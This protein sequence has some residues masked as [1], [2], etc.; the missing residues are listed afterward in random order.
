[1]ESLDAF[2]KDSQDGDNTVYE[3]VDAKHHPWMEIKRTGNSFQIVS[4]NPHVTESKESLG[5]K[6]DNLLVSIIKAEQSGTDLTEAG[7]TEGDNPFNPEDIRVHAKQFSLRL[8]ADMIKDEDIILRPDFQRNLVWTNLQKSRLIESILLRIPL[9]MFYFSEDEEGKITIVDGLQRLSTIKDFMDNKFPLKDLEYLNASCG[10]KYYKSEEGKEAIDGKYLR[11]FNQTQFSVNV[12]DP[13][14]P[15]KVKFDIFRRINTGGMPLN[16]QEIRNSLA[17]DGLRE[18]LNTMTNLQEFKSATDNSIR[19]SR[20]DDHELGLR[21]ILF[22]RFM[23]AKGTIED[24]SGYMDVSLD[25]LTDN[26]KKE[27]L[28]DL[29]TYVTSFSNA[30]RNCEYLFGS[31]FAFRKVRPSDLVAGARR[32]LINKALFVSCSV[33]LGGYDHAKLKSKNVEGALTAVLANRIDDDRKLLDY[34]SYSTNSRNNLLYV[35][36]KVQEIIKA[37]LIL[38]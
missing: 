21:F 19:T 38:S 22:Y 24:Y 16:N 18:T 23:E 34:L 12:I 17:G 31:R 30:M 10:G 26:L 32:Q 36:D 1:M 9:P 28:S 6:L 13:S 27:S 20:M 8:I 2:L 35:F 11:W 5:I 7:S 29:R 3:L 14:S 25:D 15:A 4:K 37:T 33:L